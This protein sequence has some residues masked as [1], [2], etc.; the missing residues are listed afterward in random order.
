[1]ATTSSSTV[2]IDSDAILGRDSLLSDRSDSNSKNALNSV[3]HGKTNNP[4]PPSADPAL[5]TLIAARKT[6]LHVS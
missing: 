5:H 4:P 6:I 3:S 1:M 2:M